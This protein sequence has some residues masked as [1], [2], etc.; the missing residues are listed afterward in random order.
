MTYNLVHRF[1]YCV[2]YLFKC[3][4]A[5]FIVIITFLFWRTFKNEYTSDHLWSFEILITNCTMIPYF[6]IFKEKLK[7]PQ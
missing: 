7:S 5:Y 6:Q 3:I 4:L 1:L 2:S